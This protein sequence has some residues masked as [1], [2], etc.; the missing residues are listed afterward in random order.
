VASHDGP[1]SDSPG[2][3]TP[4]IG[5][6]SIERLVEWTE[7]LY[8]GILGHWGPVSMEDDKEGD[9][10]SYSFVPLASATSSSSLG[11][12]ESG[13]LADSLESQFQ[14]VNDPSDPAVIDMVSE[15]IRAYEYAPASELKL[16]SPSEVLQAIKGLKFGKAPGPNGIPNRVM[17]H[18]HKSAKTLSS[19]GSTSR[20]HGNTLS[21]CPYWNR[22][23]TTRYLIPIDP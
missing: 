20:Q 2:Q 23:R 15:A 22:E 4:E 17:R 6:L 13:S 16:T 8:P 7:D 11:F 10:R 19:A 18:L 3:P 1:R 12:R 9:A 21:W 14:P 5:D